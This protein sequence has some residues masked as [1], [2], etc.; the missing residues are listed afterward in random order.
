[1]SRILVTGGAGFIGSH[2][3]DKLIAEANHEVVCL[4]NF[5]P[6]Y[7]RKI[8]ERNIRH[9]SENKRF[10]LIEL[11]IRDE[12]GLKQ[13]VTGTFDVIIHLA[14]MVGVRPSLDYPKKYLEVNVVGTQNLLE[15]AKSGKVRK[16]VYASS[17]SVYGENQNL[18]W[19]EDD[20]SLKPISPYAASKI[21][22]E[23]Q[24]YAYSHLYG[25]NFTALRFFTVYGPRIRPDLAIS[26]FFNN[27]LRG[28][29][30]AMYGDGSSRRD[31]TYVDDVVDGIISAMDY[32]DSNY[33]IINLGNSTT[34]EL[35][36][37][38]ATIE[39]V[40][41]KEAKINREGMKPGDVNSTYAN[42]EKANR[43]LNYSPKVSLEQGI[44]IYYKW[45]QEIAD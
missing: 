43:L 18:P 38:I 13:K 23:L 45:L 33:E 21:A 25:I 36:Q 10:Q 9:H 5:D 40:I 16:F 20:Y 42:I 24:G 19:S 11:D 35:K 27:I 12:E 14:A 7:D 34:V 39:R 6:Y 3:I 26:K 41:G 2:L 29:P 32:D 4:D 1:M 44:E 17:S 15:L 22:S 30:I 28:E 8:K 31:Y 37:L